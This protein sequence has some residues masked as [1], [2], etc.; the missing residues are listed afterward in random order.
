ML[1]EWRK[2]RKH[3]KI[4]SSHSYVCSHDLRIAGLKTFKNCLTSIPSR[5]LCRKRMISQRYIISKNIC[6]SILK[7]GDLTFCFV[8]KIQSKKF[9]STIRSETYCRE[10]F[11]NYLLKVFYFVFSKYFCAWLDEN[12]L[13][14]PSESPKGTHRAKNGNSQNCSWWQARNAPFWVYPYSRQSLQVWTFKESNE[15]HLEKLRNTIQKKAKL[16]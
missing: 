7:I 11:L 16:S 2:I 14:L 4:I 3:S 5:K 8:L 13:T 6:K 10:V 12:T 15:L 1:T 9:F